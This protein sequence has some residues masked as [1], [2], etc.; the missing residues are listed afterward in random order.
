VEKILGKKQA[1]VQDL[2][3]ALGH[4]DFKWKGPSWACFYHAVFNRRP[5]SLI[6]AR[7]HHPETLKAGIRQFVKHKVLPYEPNYLSVFP[8]NH[9]ETRRNLGDEKTPVAQLKQAA[10]RASVL[11]ALEVYGENPHHRFGMSDDDPA[12]IRLIIEE[13]TR[14]KSDYPDMSFFVI[15]TQHGDFVKREIFKDHTVDQVLL[16]STQLSLFDAK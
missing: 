13:M 3:A 8:V 7:G 11:K 12:N 5:V 10:I 6:T 1:F 9:P 14:L 16:P 4:E 15:E 2:A